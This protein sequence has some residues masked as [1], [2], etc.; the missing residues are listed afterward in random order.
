MGILWAGSLTFFTRAGVLLASLATNVLLA[1]VLGPEGRGVYTL[2]LLVP[3]IVFVIANLGVGAANVYY[4]GRRTFPIE[5]VF[6]YAFSLSLFL[7]GGA[8]LFVAFFSTVIGHVLLPDVKVSYVL[9]ASLALPEMLLA[10]F[11]QTIFQGLQRFGEFNILSATQALSQTITITFAVLV[12][13]VDAYGA[14]VAW[15]ISWAPVGLAGAALTSR[16]VP[17]SFR[18]NMRA[19]RVLLRFGLLAYLTNLT[20]FFNFRFDVIF[21]N[22]FAGV[23]QV[24]LYSAAFTLVETLWYIA[25]SAATVLAPRVASTIEGVADRL[26]AAATRIVLAVTVVASLILAL[27]ALPL[28]TTFFGNSFR[29]SVVAV[30]LLLPGVVTFSVARVLSGYFLGRNKLSVDLLATSLGLA[31]TI[32]LDL[33]LIPRLGFIGAS[34]ASSAAYTATMFV[35]VAWTVR[36]SSISLQDLLLVKRGDLALIGQRVQFKELLA[37]V[38]P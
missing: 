31:L 1:R 34:A 36:H 21:V 11:L 14:V 6:G 7:G 30:W 25:T 24:G 9:I 12:L 19:Y 15:L 16:I 35:G 2:V 13:R 29:S 28:M 26:A 23:R 38:R 17:L 8:F 5:D 4:V 27:I 10:Y 18:V 37:R 32:V 22:L 33:A 20:A 3:T